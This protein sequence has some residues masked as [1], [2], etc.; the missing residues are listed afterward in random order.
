[1]ARGYGPKVGAEAHPPHLPSAADRLIAANGMT[2]N[3]RVGV[4]ANGPRLGNR[5]VINNGLR[6]ATTRHGARATNEGR[7][8]RATVVLMGHAVLAL[9][10]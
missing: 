4:M 2:G 3:G 5:R 8:L 10:E 6:K 9:L 7:Q 1:M